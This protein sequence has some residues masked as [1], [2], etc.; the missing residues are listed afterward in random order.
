MGNFIFVPVY[1]FK[2]LEFRDSSYQGGG[3][4]VDGGEGGGGVPL[5]R[6]N[7]K[8]WQCHLFFLLIFADVPY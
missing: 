4:G 2:V 5:S 7:F 1:N 8:K 6:V 3:G